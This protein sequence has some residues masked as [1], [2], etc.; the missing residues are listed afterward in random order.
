[1]YKITLFFIL[2]LSFVKNQ[3][4]ELSI[5]Y[6]VLNGI[7]IVNVD[8]DN[9]N[10]QFAF[11]TGAFKTL[12]NSKVFTN[13]PISSKIDNVGGIS[14]V[15]K[16]MDQ[17]KFSFNFLNKKFTNK[18]VIYSDISIFTKANCEN[19]VLSGIIGR[20]IME[21]Y[22]IE[23]NPENKK[24]LFYNPSS[25]KEDKI[26]NFTR[27]KLRKSSDPRIAI[28]IGNQNRY[29]LFDTGSGN[30]MSI[31]D[32]KLERY[33]E[34][35]QHTAYKSKGSSYGIHGVNND[36]DVNHTIYN[37][38]IHIGNLNIKDQIIETSRNDFNNM[39]FSFISQFIT[40]LDLKGK[41]LY[42]KQINKNYFGESSLK[43]L[44]FYIRYDAEQKKNI[45]VTLST[46]NDKLKLG[47]NLISINGETPP[48]NNCDMYS[49]LKTFFGI[50]I[51]IKL[52][53]ENKIIEIEQTV[54]DK[55]F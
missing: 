41:N 52:E 7:P 12:I 37:A 47:D 20:D 22:I 24:I 18:E 25:F 17:V 4:Q 54:Q 44:G 46:K 15:R 55:N 38:E 16:S 29:V 28:K 9:K 32:Y 49:F 6:E 27:I 35:T 45:I 42:L 11:D 5:P 1:M 39:G 19:I 53:R 3:A 51:K 43:K 34:N 21:D 2:L 30:K 36:E 10:Y 48:E 13:L 8:I 33:I 40:Y 14:S 26:S 23:I 31:S 50:P